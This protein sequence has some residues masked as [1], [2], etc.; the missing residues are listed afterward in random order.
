MYILSKLCSPIVTDLESI[1]SA[2]CPSL[3]VNTSVLLAPKVSQALLVFP[4]IPI[5]LAIAI[6]VLLSVTC[7]LEVYPLSVKHHFNTS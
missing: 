5:W 4:R 7:I 6:A 3:L 2:L 1:S